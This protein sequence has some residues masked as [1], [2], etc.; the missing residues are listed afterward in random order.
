M[1]K[2]L[3]SIVT[4]AILASS[5]A[6]AA[7]VEKD[8]AIEAKIVS[9]IKLTKNSGRALDAIKMTYDPVKNDGHFTH[10]EQIKF[11]SLGGTKIKVSLREAFAM[12]NSNNKTFTDYK[13]NIEGKELKNGS[14]AEFFDLTNTDFS[15]SLN[16]SAKQPIDAVDGE[17]YTGVLKLSIEAEA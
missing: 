13:V 10:T 16:I 2:T 14:A 7:P 6:N 15:G 1:K 12:L 9:A 17:I 8:I 11:T 5:S 3:L 4:I